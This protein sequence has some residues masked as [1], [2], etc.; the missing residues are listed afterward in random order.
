MF[1][2]C[3][4]RRRFVS[5]TRAQLIEILICEGLEL[6]HENQITHATLREL[7]DEVRVKPN[8]TYTQ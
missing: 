6:R 7:A 3:M 2:T 1:T 4:N 8:T 5:W